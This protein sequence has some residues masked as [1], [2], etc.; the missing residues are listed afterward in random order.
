MYTSGTTGA[1]K[2]IVL[3]H[4]VRANYALLFANAFRMK[5]ES[6][7]LHTGSIVF[8]G[9]FV[10]MMPAF[11]VGATY[12][13]HKLF[14]PE[15]FIE[16]VKDER[17]THVTL[18][19]SQVIA[20]VNSPRFDPEALKSLE[21]ILSLGAPL[22]IEHKERLEAALPHRFYEL[23]GLTEGLATVLDRDDAIRKRGSVGTPILFTEMK[24]VKEDGR[25]AQ[26]RE[27]GEIVGRGPIMMTGYYK[28][29]GLTAQVIKNGWLKTGDLGFMDEDGFLYLVDRKKDMIVSGGVNVYPRDIEEI[30]AQH[31]D[32]AE[33]AV[34]GAPDERWG[35]TPVAAVQ[36]KSPCG[37]TED[38]LKVWINERVGAKYQRVSRV[39]I[40]DAFPRNT[41]GKILKRELRDMHWK[42]RDSKI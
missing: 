31:P 22:H 26:A 35:E 20:I 6:V 15:A 37:L 8:N 12:I 11:A 40:V 41:A 4:K 38:D 3:T 13:L 7:V 25:E 10:P 21:M 27:V 17:V 28:Q 1:P 39:L 23:Y 34:V 30:A 36:L 16:T 32:I 14:N 19:P 33:V 24:I 5:P 42:G 18:V 2:G 29:P 9:A